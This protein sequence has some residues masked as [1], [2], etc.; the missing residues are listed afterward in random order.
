MAEAQGRQSGVIKQTISINQDIAESIKNEHEQFTSI[1]AMA[2]TS[3]NATAAVATQAGA[4]NS[5][6]EKMTQLLEIE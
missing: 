1:N 4:I 5:M 2:D 6:V 3:A